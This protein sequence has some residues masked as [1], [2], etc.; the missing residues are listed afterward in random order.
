M[1]TVWG[2]GKVLAAVVVEYFARGVICK[3]TGK[4]KQMR[5]SV[6]RERCKE[7]DKIGL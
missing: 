2:R 5:S 3:G 4:K 6:N 7:K 1:F